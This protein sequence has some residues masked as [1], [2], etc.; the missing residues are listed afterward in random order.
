MSSVKSPSLR[1]SSRQ[2]SLLTALL[3]ALVACV[4]AAYVGE[5]LRRRAAE[6]KMRDYDILQRNDEIRRARE[7]PPKTKLSGPLEVSIQA[8]S[9]AMGAHD[10][11]GWSWRVDLPP[12]QNWWLYISQGE[13]WDENLGRYR[14][15]VSGSRIEGEGD[16]GIAGCISYDHEGGRWIQN[17]IFSNQQSMQCAQLSEEGLA[18]LRATGKATRTVTGEANQATLPLRPKPH[19]RIQLLRW[20]KVLDPPVTIQLPTGEERPL[21][22]YG[23]SIY[24][25]EETPAPPNMTRPDKVAPEASLPPAVEN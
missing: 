19:G 5:R 17:W 4:I 15:A 3:L 6:G 16:L 21:K 7:R 8:Q 24:L 13:Q 25:V 1:P 20:H 9:P 12:S 23:F 22:E 2:F 11:P 10:E 18:A 14:G